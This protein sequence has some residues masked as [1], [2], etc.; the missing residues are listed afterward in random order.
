MEDKSVLQIIGEI[1][2]GVLLMVPFIFNE[3]NDYTH[4]IWIDVFFRFIFSL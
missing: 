2:I 4:I 3:T 1:L